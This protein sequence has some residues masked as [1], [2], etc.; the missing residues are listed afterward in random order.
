[1]SHGTLYSSSFGALAT[2]ALAIRTAPV[3][4]SVAQRQALVGL[5]RTPWEPVTTIGEYV[6]KPLVEANWLIGGGVVATLI[7]LGLGYLGGRG[8]R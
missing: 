8:T 3:P 2:P 4:L 7:G 6:D 1:M 5:G